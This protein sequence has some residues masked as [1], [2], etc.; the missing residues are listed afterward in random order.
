MRRASRA[1]RSRSSPE[2]SKLEASRSSNAGL[3]CVD[4]ETN[5][6][7]LSAKIPGKIEKTQMQARRRRDLNAFQ[8]RASSPRSIRRSRLARFRGNI[9]KLCPLCQAREYVRHALQRLH[10]TLAMR[11]FSPIVPH[12]RGWCRL[13]LKAGGR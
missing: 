2:T 9:A 3:E 13:R 1:A 11:P 6:S 7:E 10:A 8:L 5:R 4:G 12:R